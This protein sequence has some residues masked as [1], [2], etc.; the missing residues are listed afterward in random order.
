MIHFSFCKD[1]GLIQLTKAKGNRLV[2]RGEGVAGNGEL[3]DAELHLER[4]KISWYAWWWC[5]PSNTNLFNA[6]DLHFKNKV[7]NLMSC[8]F[9]YHKKE[10]IMGGGVGGGT[11]GGLLG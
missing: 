11:C 4:W 5:V 2:V 8:V 3:L 6:I 9:E 1:S 10:R 7:V